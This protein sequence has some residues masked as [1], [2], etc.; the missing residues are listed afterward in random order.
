MTEQK[1]EE[2]QNLRLTRGEPIICVHGGSVDS[3]IIPN[4]KKKPWD[5][6]ASKH[7]AGRV[8]LGRRRP[9]EC[10]KRHG[11]LVPISGPHSAG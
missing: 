3:A 8:L 7:A 2:E 1:Q 10:P 5:S 6:V 11:N 4:R 9:H